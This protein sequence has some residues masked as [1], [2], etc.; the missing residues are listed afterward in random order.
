[1]TTSSHAGGLRDGPGSRFDVAVPGRAGSLGDSTGV[2]S[3]ST[4]GSGRTGRTWA[5]LR[6]PDEIARCVNVAVDVQPA[7]IAAESA[8]STRQLH[9]NSPAAGAA[10]AAGEPA[11]AHH[12][13]AAVPGALVLEHAAQLPEAAVEHRTV[14]AGF[15]PNVTPRCVPCAASRPRHATH[16]EVLDDE[17]AVALGKP[18]GQDM[19]VV[20][21]HARDT[22]MGPSQSGLG[23]PASGASLPAARHRPL[24]PPQ[25]ALR[26]AQRSSAR[27]QL[28]SGERRKRA[29]A[30][31]DADYILAAVVN[32]D[33]SLHQTCEA[34]E[35]A[36]R[37][38]RHSGAEDASAAHAQAAQ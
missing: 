21:P 3:A 38:T 4:P 29:H 12:E 16:V 15:G 11:V 2:G 34:H 18:R 28:A 36:V 14:L 9:A 10:F 35:P 8:L 33:S 22:A 17:A 6:P 26:S 31:I 25:P 32:D 23:A 5:G 27:H 1:M 20:P 13:P 37:L 19:E 30:E 7:A 24:K